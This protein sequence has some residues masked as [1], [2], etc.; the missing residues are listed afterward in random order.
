MN[1][2]PSKEEEVFTTGTRVS[3]SKA[4]MFSLIRQLQEFLKEWRTPSPRAQITAAPIDVRELWSKKSNRVPGILSLLAHAAVLAIAITSSLV[5]VVKYKAP[6]DDAVLI[7]PYNLSPPVSGTQSGGG[8]MR[9]PTPAS[10]GVL[11][12]TAPFQLVPPTPFI[13]Q[14]PAELMA[15]PT[16]IA[17]DLSY[18]PNRNLGLPLGDPN[19]P[20]GPPSGGPGS[21]GGIGDGED[22]GVGD[23]FG[24]KAG[25]NGDPALAPDLVRIGPGGASAPLC[26]APATDPAYT[27]EARK[28]H[29][30]GKVILDAIVN[31]D[32]SI[33]ISSI[34][35]KLGYG[36]DDEASRF[37]TRNFRCRPGL[38]QGQAVATPIRIDVNFHLY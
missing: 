26:P 31:R 11:P 25:G 38:Y 3:D 21:T 4:W 10:R 2:T 5:S 1:L 32:G 19:G 36:L 6:V 22:H 27:D 37:V 33:T 12:E 23:K 20:I 14:V 17:A 29:I 24:P 15:V 13:T 28:A 18:L 35:Q 34:V 8:G 9:S 16:I 7:S 30:Q